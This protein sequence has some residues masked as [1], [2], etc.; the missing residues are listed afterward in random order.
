M[1][2]ALY[3]R[4]KENEEKIRV[5]GPHITGLVNLICNIGLYPFF[6]ISTQLS[7]S[8]KPSPNYRGKQ[9]NEKVYSYVYASHEGNR[10]YR[11]AKFH[12]YTSAFIHNSLQGPTSFF[13][14]FAPSVLSF[15]LSILSRSASTSLLSDKTSSFPP[16]YRIFAGID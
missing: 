14:G 6:Q 4:L 1:E 10:P 15:Y 9:F 5:Y 16:I 7:L 8:S 11:P 2:E 3:S 13:K 12:N